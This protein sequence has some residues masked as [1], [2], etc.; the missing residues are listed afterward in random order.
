MKEL[1]RFSFGA[2]SSI[3]T[4][5]SLIVGLYSSAKPKASI[6]SALIILAI[7]DNVSDSLGIHIYRESEDAHKSKL[8]TITNFLTRLF[9]TC[10]F[11]AFVLFLPKMYG[12]SISIAFG[13]IVLSTLSYF[14][15]IDQNISPFREILK[16]LGI[17]IALM[18]ASHFL[19]DLV[20]HRFG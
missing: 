15:A 10:I 19:G 7:A 4:S 9:L 18:I 14:I 20:L 1:N 11:A 6:I 8:H 13:I 17:A 5:L 16:H 12:M 3:T 2:T